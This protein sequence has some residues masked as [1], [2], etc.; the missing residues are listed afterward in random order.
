MHDLAIKF[1]EALSSDLAKHLQP[2]N[3]EVGHDLQP[4]GRC[5]ELYRDRHARDGNNPQAIRRAARRLEFG[6]EADRQL[7]RSP[8][9]GFLQGRGADQQAVGRVQCHGQNLP[10]QRRT[11]GRLHFTV[12]RAIGQPYGSSGD[13]WSA[14]PGRPWKRR[15]AL[16]PA[17][18]KAPTSR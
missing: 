14:K 18:R 8:D 6:F 15:K 17:S 5:Q 11:P 1:A 9:R 3:R 13:N 10:G 12:R 7:T 16:P 2:I 4:H